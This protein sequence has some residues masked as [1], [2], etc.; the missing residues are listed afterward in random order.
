MFKTNAT[1]E[2]MTNTVKAMSNT[3]GDFVKLTEVKEV[4]NEITFPMINLIRSRE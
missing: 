3:Y 4:V 2:Q 1:D